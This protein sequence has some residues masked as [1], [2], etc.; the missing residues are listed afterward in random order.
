MKTTSK[1]IKAKV[2]TGFLAS[3]LALSAF[4]LSPQFGS[5]S[6]NVFSISS[7]LA[8]AVKVDAPR[9][10]GFADVVEAVSPAVVSVR[11]EQMIQPA[12]DDEEFRFDRRFG[13]DGERLPEFF[14]NNPDLFKR[15]FR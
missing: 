7:A 6:E 1:S 10:P 13:K 5:P 15:F 2:T 9:A 11:V 12:S 8:D 14:R 4:A 3:A